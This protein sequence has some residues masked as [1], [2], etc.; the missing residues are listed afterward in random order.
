M[1]RLFVII[2]AA[3]SGTR[4]GKNS[5]KLF[6]DIEGKPVIERTIECFSGTDAE[7]VLA[8]N[9]ENM[10]AL[11][12][13]SQK[14]PCISKVVLG[15]A[16]RTESVYK[17]FLALEDLGACDT[18][19]VFIHDGARCLLPSEVIDNCIEGL[20][21]NDVCVAGVAAKN[22]IKTIKDGYVDQ[23][24]DRSSLVEIQTPQCF[25]Y[26]ILRDSY[27]NATEKGIE[28]TDD[29]ALS[30]ALGIPTLVVEGSYR[31]IKITTPEDILMA[32]ALLNPNK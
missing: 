16:S 9:E 10:E 19:M 12:Q 32:S 28:A 6:M 3:G 29:T 8:T 2:P 22:T 31:N 24:L 25:R 4:M 17:G 18:D 1:D 27:A 13:L 7:L 30:E 26:S 21:K 15:G 11:E 23:L 20:K 5:N 14:Y